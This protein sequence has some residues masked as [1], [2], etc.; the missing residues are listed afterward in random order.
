MD[1]CVALYEVELMEEA[2]DLLDDYSA[3]CAEAYLRYMA[4]YYATNATCDED[5]QAIFDAEG[6]AEAEAEAAFAC[7][8]EMRRAPARP[9]RRRGL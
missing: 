9:E 1:G 3:G 4:C 7:G 8:D 6:C 5:G 2:K